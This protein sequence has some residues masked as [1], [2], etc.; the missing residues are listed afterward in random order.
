[1]RI[2]HF[3]GGNL[4]ALCSLGNLQSHDGGNKSAA[5]ANAMPISLVAS[6]HLARVSETADAVH[7][8]HPAAKRLVDDGFGECN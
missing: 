7:A 2:P 6:S 1:M 3:D 5:K 8:L 4:W